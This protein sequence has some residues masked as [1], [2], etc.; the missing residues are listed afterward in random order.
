MLKAKDRFLSK[1][2][3]PINKKDC[4]IWNACTKPDGYGLFVYKKKIRAH[5]FSY[6]LFIGD[7]PKNKMV[8]HKCDIR[9]CVNPKHL[10]L[11]THKQNMRDKKI[12]GRGGGGGRGKERIN[13]KATEW[14]IKESL[15]II[16]LHFPRIGLYYQSII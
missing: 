4:W 12:K 6:M 11:G 13:L 14:L 15:L 9:N 3:I 7:I 5:R 8:C 1:V 10:W 16:Y 2:K